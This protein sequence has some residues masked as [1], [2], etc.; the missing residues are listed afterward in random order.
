LSI[1]SVDGNIVTFTENFD[2]ELA[3]LSAKTTE[4]FI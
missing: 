1:D 4:Q 3:K 2:N